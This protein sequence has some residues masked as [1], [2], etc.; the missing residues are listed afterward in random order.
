MAIREVNGDV[1]AGRRGGVRY[2]R[3]RQ[4]RDT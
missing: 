1:Y 2:E 4:A 3:G